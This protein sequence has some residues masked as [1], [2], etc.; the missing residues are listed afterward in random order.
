MVRQLLVALWR[1]AATG[2]VPFGAVLSP[3]ARASSSIDERKGRGSSP[4]SEAARRG[5]GGEPGRGVFEKTLGSPPPAAPSSRWNPP[6]G[7]SHRRMRHMD[8]GAGIVR[9]PNRTGVDLRC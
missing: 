2:L 5:C 1:Y 4:E 6:P 8:N 9:W 7:T 3:G